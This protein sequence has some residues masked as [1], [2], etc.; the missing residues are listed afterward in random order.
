MS[1]KEL[2]PQETITAIRAAIQPR[3]R[4]PEE[5]KA[6]C[7]KYPFLK[8]YGDPLYVGYSEDHEID[9][10]Y[11]WEDEIPLGWRKAFCPQMWDE[12]LE[13]L[14]KANYVNDFRFVQIKEKYS[15][16]R[17]YSNGAPSSIFEEIMAWE[18]KYEHLSETVCIDCGAPATHM[19][20]GWINFICKECAQNRARKSL[21]QYGGYDHYVK[22]EN[23]EE[24]YNDRESYWEKHKDD[25]I[26]KD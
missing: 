13:I 5:N 17:L 7:E 8:W 10:T 18:M 20:T 1:K 4:T 11:T 9:Y 16:L 23:I 25:D 12:L 2:T 15:S 3:S 21:E 24:F 6:L 22:M 14:K 19:S 26:L